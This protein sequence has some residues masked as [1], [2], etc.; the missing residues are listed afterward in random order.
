[1][2][3]LQITNQ[4]TKDEISPR[5][6]ATRARGH[7]GPSSLDRVAAGHPGLAV[8][9]RALLGALLPRRQGGPVT[10][11]AIEEHDLTRGRQVGDA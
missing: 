7:S 8:D 10:P 2:P 3:T 4:T 5:K 11:A 6:R 1:M 9:G